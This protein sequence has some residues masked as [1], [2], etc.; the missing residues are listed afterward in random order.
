MCALIAH[1]GFES[2]S[3]RHE[4]SELW[5]ADKGS[6]FSMLSVPCGT[7]E[8]FSEEDKELRHGNPSYCG[9]DIS[10]RDIKFYVIIN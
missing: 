3:F 9:S 1:P 4:K 10:L 2:L 8:L 6:L 5:S 7:G